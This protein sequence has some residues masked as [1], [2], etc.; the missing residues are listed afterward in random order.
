MNKKGIIEA[1]DWISGLVGLLVLLAGLIPLLESF[2]ILNLGF[3]NIMGTSAFLT[4][5]PFI[6][7]ALGFYLAIESLIELTNS[8]HIGW[9]SFFVG[10][11]IMVVGILPALQSFGIG[12]GLFGLQPPLLIYNI[13][14]VI[15]GVFLV[16]A[17][18][19]MEL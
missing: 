12:P 18:F 11:I 3:S 9:L 17:M 1:K 14:F 6:L 4:V 19:A 10:T 13:I 5:L 7:A 16:I 15:E 8:N 2:G